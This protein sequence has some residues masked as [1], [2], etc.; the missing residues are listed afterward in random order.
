M[1][2]AAAAVSAGRDFIRKPTAKGSV[3]WGTEEHVADVARR[4]CDFG[5][6]PDRVTVMQFGSDPPGALRAEAER[7]RPDLVV[8]DTLAAYAEQAAPDS[9]SASAWAAIMRPLVRMARELGCAV[10]ILHH[11]RRSDGKYRDS[12]EIGAAVDVIAELSGS[13]STARRIEYRGRYGRGKFSVRL[14]GHRF[15]LVDGDAGAPSLSNAMVEFV[16]ANPGCSHNKIMQGVP[17]STDD[18]RDELAILERNEKIANTGTKTRHEY[19]I[20][21]AVLDPPQKTT[22]ARSQDR[23]EDQAVLTVPAT[24]TR[25]EPEAGSPGGPQWSPVPNLEVRTG[26]TGTDCEPVQVSEEEVL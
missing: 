11:A 7:L 12:G 3:L 25:P 6:H 17:G 14:E 5:A 10:V 22:S 9:G 23:S 24:R 15:E 19:R 26:T 18:K 16:R 13:N 20:V 1:T 2:D 8:V 4:M 21:E